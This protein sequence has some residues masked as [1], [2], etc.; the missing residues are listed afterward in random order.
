MMPKKDF[1]AKAKSFTLETDAKNNF[2]SLKSGGSDVATTKLKSLMILEGELFGDFR[3]GIGSIFFIERNPQCCIWFLLAD[4]WHES[5][6][7]C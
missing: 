5:C 7:T 4:G 6:W 2:V 3:P 1:V